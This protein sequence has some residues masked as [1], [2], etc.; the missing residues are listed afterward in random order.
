MEEQCGWL[1]DATHLEA[2]NIPHLGDNWNLFFEGRR[3]WFL[4]SCY[5]KTV[6]FL[7]WVLKALVIASVAVLFSCIHNHGMDIYV[8]GTSEHILNYSPCTKYV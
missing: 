5:C 8:Q 4:F 2:M 1:A 7:F 3:I 6:R